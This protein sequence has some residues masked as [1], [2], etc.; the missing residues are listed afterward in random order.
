M[1]QGISANKQQSFSKT[2]ISSFLSCLSSGLQYIWRSVKIKNRTNLSNS[3]E[4]SEKD[5]K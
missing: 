3:C 4:L 5:R 2:F 1:A